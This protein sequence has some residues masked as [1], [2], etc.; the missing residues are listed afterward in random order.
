MHLGVPT[1]A[2]VLTLWRIKN[3]AQRVAIAASISGAGATMAI[4]PAGTPMEAAKR[5][6]PATLMNSDTCHIINR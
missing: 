2:T 3:R 4:S 6:T 5:I 1:F